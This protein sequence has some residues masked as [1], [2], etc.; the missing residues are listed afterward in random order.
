MK[1]VLYFSAVIVCLLV[2]NNLLHSIYDL[3]HKQDLVVSAQKDLE[4]QKEENKRL[5]L[6]LT[7]VNSDKFV[8]QEARDKLLLVKPGE[9]GVIL[10]D[11][12]S[13]VTKKEVNLPNWQK[14][15]KL[16]F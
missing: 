11:V 8:E 6:H 10:P 3:W 9:S 12:A 1:K 16:F 4:K 13:K 5:K 7:Q 2:I 14:W 15:L